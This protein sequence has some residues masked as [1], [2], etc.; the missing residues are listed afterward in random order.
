MYPEICAYLAEQ[1]RAYN[2]D[3]SV[4]KFNINVSVID[5]VFF[6]VVCENPDIF[7]VDAHFFETT[8][9]NDT[10]TLVSIRPTYLFEPEEIP[11]KIDE[12]EKAAS[13][14]R[15]QISDDLSDAYK[16][17]YL[18]DLIA[19][20]VHYDMDV[21]NQNPN[22]RTAYGALIEG[23]C[24]CEGYTLAYNY[25]LSQ[26]G[27]E[28][29]FVQS[30]KMKHT[31]SLVKLQDKYYHVD[32]THDD[33]SYDTLGRVHH[34]YV[35]LSDSAIKENNSHY[36][37][38]SSI[39]A[40]D[41][42]YDNMWWKK[43]NSVIYPVDGHDYY[44]NQNYTSSGYGAFIQ[45]NI[46]TGNE[47]CIEKIYT[48]WTVDGNAD[49]AFWDKAYSY[50]TFDGVYFYYN[51]T[52]GVYRHRPGNESYFDVLYR[53]PEPVNDNIYGIAMQLDGRLYISLKKSPN[54]E[55]NLFLIDK[56]ILNQNA[57]Q[58][59]P[60]TENIFF[61]TEDGIT[62]CEY[63][64]RSE[65]LTLPSTINDKTII[66][67]GDNIFSDRAE[68]KS[69]IIP[70]GVE[71]LGNSVFYN[72]PNLESVV[73]PET[74]RE[75]GNS[76]FYGCTSLEEITI[77]KSVTKLGKNTFS[78]CINLT[79]KGYRG[80]IAETYASMYKI[81]F[82]ALDEASETAPTSPTQSPD[83]T[84]EIKTKTVINKSDTL[85]ISQSASLHP[86]GSGYKYSSSKKSV[87]SV[88]GKGVITARK[89]GT[90]VIKIENDEVIFK[91][92]LTVKKPY[93]NRKKLT[94]KK[95]GS[96]KLKI[97]GQFGL[98]TFKSSNKKV[99]TVGRKGKIRA[100]KKGFAV[101]TVKTNG[102]VKLK[103]RVKVK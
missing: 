33:P 97:K 103:C 38:I 96:F 42:S 19:Q 81:H 68:L 59:V 99:V 79:I 1:F 76:A 6:S 31:W 40:D 10:G 63:I 50:L 93:L 69:I 26:L 100:K 23:N 45:R 51:D 28:A 25:I 86:E 20:Y 85:Y 56:S 27:I 95:G 62:L 29:H 22:I 67:L 70:E 94:L 89:K 73:L 101:I 58:P 60:V 12:F 9:V 55:D 47:H 34:D 65:K 80:S 37:W 21:Y 2:T 35:L 87:V 71:Q 75:I 8:S 49:G 17:R 43:I 30:L 57:E 74:L 4:E 64:D 48:R 78:G 41:T 98:A 82:I 102:S 39:K 61:E 44:I 84:P 7:Y 91:V 15:L 92:K 52:G 5:A 36:D 11:A 16:C 46:N 54:V 66:T 88:T 32:I 83:P 90:A 77:P 72:C 3:I 18:H 14:V 24:V 53:K 13:Y